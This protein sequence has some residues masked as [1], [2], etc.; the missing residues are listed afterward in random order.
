MKEGIKRSREKIW[1]HKD[2][3]NAEVREGERKGV[4]KEKWVKELENS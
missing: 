4:G 2:F 1:I 3:R